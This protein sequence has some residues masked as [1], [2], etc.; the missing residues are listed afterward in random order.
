MVVSAVVTT[1][2]IATNP[3]VRSILTVVTTP[4]KSTTDRT[5]VIVPGGCDAPTVPLI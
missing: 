1:T 2:L 5:I 4:A 3:N